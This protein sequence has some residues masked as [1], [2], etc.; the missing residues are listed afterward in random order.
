MKKDVKFITEEQ[1]LRYMPNDYFQKDAFWN[2]VRSTIDNNKFTGNFYSSL[3][4]G[5]GDGYLYELD[6]HDDYLVRRQNLKEGERIYRY[7]TR[8]SAFT[9]QVPLIKINIDKGLLYFLK[10]DE[11]GLDLIEFETKGIPVRYLNIIPPQKEEYANG[12]MMADGGEMQFVGITDDEGNLIDIKVGDEVVQYKKRYTNQEK[13]QVG[14]KGRVIS[15]NGGFAKVSYGNDYEQWVVLG[16]LKK[17]D[18]GGMMDDGGGIGEPED[19][20]KLNMEFLKIFS[21]YGFIN[22]VNWGDNHYIN[23]KGDILSWSPKS[24]TIGKGWLIVRLSKTY[25]YEMHSEISK[26]ASNIQEEHPDFKINYESESYKR[27]VIKVYLK[28]YTINN[29]IKLFNEFN[30]KK[31]K[32][33]GN[34]SFTPYYASGGMMADGAMTNDGIGF[35]PMD[36]EQK[37]M[38]TAKWGGTDIKGVIGILN[39][40]IDSN[41][42]DEDLLPKPTKSGSAF[43]KAVAKKTQE[44]WAKIEPNYK[45]N[46]IGNKYYGTIRKLVERSTTSDEILKR[47]KPFRKYQKNSVASNLKMADGGMMAQGGELKDY[48]S[49]KK[50]MFDDNAKTITKKDIIEVISLSKNSDKKYWVKD[51]NTKYSYYIYKGNLRAND[52]TGGIFSTTIISPNYL[53]DEHRFKVEQ[54]SLYD[55]EKESD[56]SIVK[57]GWDAIKQKF[58]KIFYMEQDGDDEIFANEVK[59]EEQS[60]D[61]FGNMTRFTSR[62]SFADAKSMFLRSLTPEEAKMIDIEYD[63][64]NVHELFGLM[65]EKK[66]IIKRKKD[67]SKDFLDELENMNFEDDSLYMK[68]GGKLAWQNVQVGDKALVLSENKL[69][70]VMK[71]Y[72]RRFHLKFP[73]GTEKTYSAEELEFFEDEEYAEG[74]AIGSKKIAYGIY[75]YKGKYISAYHGTSETI[76]NIFNDYYLQNEYAIG[77]VSKKQAMSYIDTQDEEYAEGGGLL[78]IPNNMADEI[79]KSISMG[80]DIIREGLISPK[81]KGIMLSNEDYKVRGTFPLELK[82]AIQKMID[83]SKMKKGG[84][85][86]GGVKKNMLFDKNGERRIDPEAIAYIENTVEMLPQT[87]FMYTTDDGKYKPERK[88]LHDEIIATFHEGK[89]CINKRPAVAILTGGAPASGKTTFIKKYVDLDPEKVYHV[90]ADEVRA[91]LP[92]YRGWNA[93]QTHLETADIVNRLIDDI[94]VPCD[95]DLIYDG[96]MN[97]ATKYEKIVDKLHKLGYKVFV[98]YISIPEQV[99]KERVIAR[100]KKA[101]R[102]VPMKVIE[103]VY[104]MGLTAF[105]KVAH[106]MADGY[107]RID[108]MNGEIIEEG[109]MAMPS[110]IEYDKGGKIDD[111]KLKNATALVRSAERFAEMETGKPVK[112]GRGMASASISDGKRKY[113]SVTVFFEDGTITTFEEEEFPKFF[114]KDGGELGSQDYYDGFQMQVV[115]KKGNPDKEVQKENVKMSYRKGGKL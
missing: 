56:P 7:F 62:V 46:F 44:I 85:L 21:E 42:T 41:I 101:G 63:Y 58:D 18:K 78:M 49:S 20:H 111:N 81:R 103:E 106:E 84:T 66:F 77:F 60:R 105:E 51:L 90:D 67:E 19:Y 86:E 96:T 87:K 70:L 83:D 23:E 92:E 13:D 50:D 72:G 93:T 112:K 36:L 80:Y 12:G 98:V 15:I 94:G 3:W 32:I 25:P 76:W 107:I 29:L 82:N 75:L 27:W 115:Q 61:A 10:E 79:K 6:E 73:D 100:Y 24:K 114:M 108:G 104:D 31:G 4:Q 34:L 39:A 69:G 38:I 14:G 95:H 16:E 113:K 64:K 71:P 109:G 8:R 47:Y 11:E 26:I 53:K 91:M 1:A 97:K 65:S 54:Q 57:V 110:N 52:G 17:M 45:G 102:Y 5:G 55:W 22:A 48:L 89:P 59:L 40:M 99:S 68:N 74:G 2:K 43:E 37:L 9:G 30:F 35:I 88:K 33:K 28:S